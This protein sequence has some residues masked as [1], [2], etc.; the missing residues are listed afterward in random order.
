MSNDKPIKLAILW[1]MHQPNYQ[2][3]ESNRL[4]MPWVR[5]HAIKD[6]LDMPLLAAN[7]Q[8]KVTFNLVPSLID[9]IEY[10]STGATDRHLELSRVPAEKLNEALRVEILT[11]FFSANT[12]NMIAPNSRYEELHRKARESYGQQILPAVFSSEEMRDLQV[13]SNLCWVDPM[14][15]QEALPRAL[16]A[17]GRHFSEEEKNA[18]L[19]WQLNLMKRIMPA[20][21]DLYE[22]DQIDISFTPY[23]H[24]ILP[25]LCDTNSALE[26]MPTS[27]LPEHRFVHPE[28]SYRQIQMAAE[29]FES[30]FGKKMVGMWPSEGSVSEEVCRQMAQL[31]V[32]WIATDEQILFQSLAKSG[33]SRS[34]NPLQTVYQFESGVKMFFRDHAL[35]D[36]I[37]FVY[38]G[39][40]ADRAVDDFLSSIHNV[41]SLLESHL[42]NAVISVILDG[43]NAWEYFPDDGR[44]FLELLYGRLADDPLIEP[45]TMSEAASSITPRSLP[46]LYAGSWIN[47]NFRIWIGH[48]EDNAAWDLLSAARD[49]L[50]EFALENPGFDPE[51]L[52]LAWRQIY[53][54]EGSDWCWWYGD[55]HRSDHND[56]FDLAFRRHLIAV[57][58]YIGVEVPAGLHKPIF[59]EKSIS[60]VAL[61]E[62]LITPEI[63]GRLS[64]FYE[65]SGA[66]WFDCL[67][68]GQAM[69]RVD[70]YI[71]GIHFGFDHDCLYVRLD[72]VDKKSIESI[73][74]PIIR[75]VVASPEEKEINLGLSTENTPG[76]VSGV[77]YSFGDLLEMAV[78]RLFLNEQGFGPVKLS[79]SLLDGDQLLENWPENDALSFDIAQKN[80]EMFWPS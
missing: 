44:E 47:R 60:Q 48:E 28:D 39:W 51:K 36:R 7:E 40:D 34:D 33:M 32:Q 77:R 42:D 59:R 29:K 52:E 45:V 35:S 63:D 69:H 22:K 9:Q 31:G 76:E 62:T 78:D 10:Y 1:H 8:V 64:N 55:E 53:I 50:Q 61:P 65:W 43:E 23:Y 54:A 74:Q 26:S 75:L 58:K 3:P 41:R 5:L 13:W 37:G 18:L 71:S 56:Q 15:R 80:E 16:F 30:L 11:S 25:L 4:S 49:K 20:Y 12:T 46:R 2:E 73:K 21:R 24:P 38:S 6:Y 17:K 70:R 57:Y 19:D 67:K 79:I 68:S 27:S 72:F 66:G 14:F